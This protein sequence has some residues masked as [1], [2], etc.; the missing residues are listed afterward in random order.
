MPK[1]S[2]TLH[3]HVIFA[4]FLIV[5]LGGFIGIWAAQAEL[6]SAVIAPGKIV[7][8]ENVKKLQHADGGIIAEINVK[9]GDRVK[10]GDVM[11]RLDTTEHKAELAILTAQLT[12]LLARSARLNA[13]AQGNGEITFPSGYEKQSNNARTAANAERRL[14]QDA[15][16]HQKGRE[17]ELELQISQLKEESTGLKAEQKAKQG[18]I[19]LIGLELKQ[20]QQL[21][22]KNLTSVTRLYALQREQKRLEGEEGSLTARLART[23]HKISE[24]KLQILTLARERKLEAQRER[25]AVVARIAELKEKASAIAAR[26]KRSAVKA[27][28]AGLVHELAV[29]TI[30]GVI[31]PAET[32]MFIVPD[33]EKL[34]IEV[35]VPPA[36]IDQIKRG[37]TVRLRFSAFNQNTTPEL[38]GKLHHVAADVTIDE[39]SREAFYKARISI[40]RDT[41]AS[42]KLIPGMPVEAFI[43]T[44]NR[45]ALS[46]FTKPITDQFTRALRE[47]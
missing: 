12:E 40:E 37:Q 3:R 44:S 16:T 13:E 34:T 10:A 39:K 24:T 29:H 45:T 43:M 47:E 23:A 5:A 31:T 18:Q 8:D 42:L 22:K 19:H 6:S 9:N 14:L 2:Y 33:H 7:I 30:G 11:I 46:Y 27:P 36:D 15:R 25:R 28:R 4:I 17:N 21:Y 26:L 38:Q 41:A 1:S 20:L 35:K 32:I